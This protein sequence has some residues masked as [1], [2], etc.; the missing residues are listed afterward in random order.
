MKSS[1]VRHT[2]LL[3]C[4]N[5][6]NSVDSH[7]HSECEAY[8]ITAPTRND[9]R[10]SDD[11]PSPTNST[12][13]HHLT[14]EMTNDMLAG[15]DN[16][17]DSSLPWLLTN[18]ATMTPCTPQRETMPNFTLSE[19]PRHRIPA[20]SMHSSLPKQ[21]HLPSSHS[22]SANSEPS[23]NAFSD[24]RP[25]FPS[26]A[27]ID[28][29]FDYILDCIRASGFDNFDAVVSAYYT[30]NFGEASVVHN[31]QKVSRN[32]RLP[33]VLIDLRRDV[34]H[35]THWEAHGY[36]DQIVRSAESILVAEFDRFMESNSAKELIAAT[37]TRIDDIGTSNPPSMDAMSA[38]NPDSKKML[39]NEV[40]SFNQFLGLGNHSPPCLMSS[41]DA[42]SSC[43][44]YWP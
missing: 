41:T 23:R 24:S 3:K 10:K 18:E 16:L 15:R 2:S 14:S 33:D 19:S 34:G 38:A 13:W 32:R 40:S 4:M 37:D 12:S 9:Q 17:L 11:H 25:K 29:R 36:E 42:A 26:H 35:W 27:N 5:G 39:K 8:S 6:L 22:S 7:S 1:I 43:Q 44:I 20:P 28:E 30:G 21:N 31:A